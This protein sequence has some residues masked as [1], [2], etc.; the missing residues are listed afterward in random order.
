M[1]A[2]ITS[3]GRGGVS[4]TEAGGPPAAQRAAGA[5]RP[6]RRLKPGSALFLLASIAVSFIAASSAPTPLYAVY[7]AQWHFSAITTTVVFGVYA[8]AVLVAL[9]VLGRL[10]DYLGRRPIILS[11]VIVQIAAL[12][13]LSTAHGVPELLVGRIV[14]GLAAG[15]ALGAIGAGMLDIDRL[16]GTTLNAVSMG[17]GTATGAMVSSLFVQYLPLPTHLIYIVLIAVLAVQAVG[18]LFTSET[19]ER[20]RGAAHSLVP[21]IK[22]PRSVRGAMLASAPVLFAAWALAGFFLALGPVLVGILTGSQSVVYGGLVVLV[23]AGAACAA[24]M[25]LQKAE[26]RKVMLIGITALVVG[27]ALTVLSVQIGATALFFVGIVVAGIGFGSGFQGGIR[28]VVPYVQPHERAGV[29]SIIYVVSYLGFGLPAVIAG[30]F[31]VHSGGL[32]PVERIYGFAVI[33][34]ALLALIG[35]VRR[36]SRGTQ[37]A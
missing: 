24:V 8:I 17:L 35:L 14:Q 13:V 34:L 22:L 37:A 2:D 5:A 20:A 16:R 23:F 15:I 28:T 32:I 11:G 6:G 26:G 10:S 31:V 4:G 12:V 25:S 7:Q 1:P 30:Y 19:V 36:R 9:L 27:V 29:L 18:V 3:R 21:E 33:A